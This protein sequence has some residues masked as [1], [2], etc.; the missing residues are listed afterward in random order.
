[1]Q[2]VYC[3]T[4]KRKAYTSKPHEQEKP[5][6]PPHVKIYFQDRWSNYVI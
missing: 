2:H 3:K 4:K 5:E 6:K 1:M